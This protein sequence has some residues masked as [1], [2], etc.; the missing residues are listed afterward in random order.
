[1]KPLLRRLVVAVSIFA[2]GCQQPGNEKVSSSTAAPSAPLSPAI[3]AADLR[4]EV[5]FIASDECEG[6]LTGSPG[7]ARAAQYIAGA[8]GDAGL[9]PISRSEGFFQPF[10]FAAGVSMVPGKSEMRVVEQIAASDAGGN[11]RCELD[12]DFRPLA[13]SANG[14]LEAGVVF[15]GYGLAEPRSAG[16]GY[17][18]YANLDVKGKVVLALRG[19]PEN[20]SPQRRQELS[21]Y[22]GDRYKA[23]LAA[24]HGAIAFMLVTGPNSAN[25]GE[26]VKLCPDDRE[27][28]A[29][30]V[31]VSV[32]GSL[33]QRLL[34][35][36]G[37]NL[38]DLQTKHDGEEVNPHAP[39]ALAG[40]RVRITVEL[41]RLEKT[42]RNVIGLIPPTG[43]CDEYVV[44]G[45]HYDHIGRGSGLGSLAHQGEEEQIHNGADDNASG[46][47][48]VL[49]LAAAVAAERR[50]GDRALPRR[51]AVFACWSGE[52][53]GLIGSTY[54][55]GHPAVPL[56]K[57]VAY[58]NF[59]MIGRLRDN[60][61]ILQALG[62]S[63]AWRELADRCNAAAGFNLVLQEDP[64]L[65]SDA[66]AFYTKGV[67][68]L[69]F[70]TGSHEDY[71]RPTDDPAT[72]NYEGLQRITA[73]A[74]CLVDDTTEPGR[75]IPYARV[76]QAAPTGSRGGPRAYT[77]TVP[78]FA[79]GD[80]Q[81]VRIADV[82]PGGP[83]DQ[84]G[85]KGGDVIVEF[86]GSKIANLQDYSDAL[87]GVKI[88]QAAPI[89]VE[90]AGERLT[91]TITPTARP[92]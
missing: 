74:K 85:L 75:A 34:S 46:V 26:M 36:A 48:A 27:A 55:A 29:P 80:V 14:A 39:S 52:E 92:E 54:F 76:Q 2:A 44:L 67:P 86:A 42:C 69:A 18:S 6:R 25:A 31:A 70:F 63:P 24:E 66:T 81:G 32:S 78:D 22:A 21:V 50:T 60:K 16:Q 89:V 8:F 65:P 37:L 41:Q 7:A 71:N 13:F 45:A 61:L 5:N 79:G 47:S 82:R 77:G 9:Q 40:V 57:V 4:A 56:N 64:Y 72:L 49:E 83:A 3:S 28:V 62:S 87:I 17:D 15:V 23:K 30:I 38:K 11:Q 59:D 35:K 84:A 73:F 58:L 68:V 91:L 33:A 53:L 10:D 20:A 88:G 12:K 1:M 43:G 51:G 90:R 19:L